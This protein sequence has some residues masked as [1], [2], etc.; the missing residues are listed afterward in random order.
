MFL[1]KKLLTALALPPLSLIL[2]AALGLGLSRRHPRCGRWLT[3]VSLLTFGFLSL[4]MV[5]GALLHS[6][7]P[8]PPVSASQLA[9]AQAIVILA[10]GLQH[11]APEYGGDTVNHFSLIRSRYG[12]RLQ[13]QSGLPILVSGGAPTGGKPEGE[14]MKEAIE[15]DF[16]AQVRWVE[17]RS[18]DTQDNARLS[19][20]LLQADG[21]TRIVLVSHAWHLRRAMPLFTQQGLEVIAAPTGF[22]STAPQAWA[23]SLPNAKAFSESCY[24]LHEW[25]GIFVQQLRSIL[26]PDTRPK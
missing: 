10:G 6:L 8:Y 3:G 14:A 13:K 5:A 26:S 18:L 19:A 22:S 2:L 7:A 4:P 20:R 24:A 25:L 23:M 17:A 21:I 9:Q 1:L 15:Q 16:G 12:A 11:D